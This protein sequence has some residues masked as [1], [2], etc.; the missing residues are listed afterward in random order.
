MKCRCGTPFPVCGETE[1]VWC[2]RCLPNDLS[3]HKRR[4]DAQR[5][6][7]LPLFE[8]KPATAEEVLS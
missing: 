7:E 5:N 2:L 6:P 3:A 1:R 8:S 4:E